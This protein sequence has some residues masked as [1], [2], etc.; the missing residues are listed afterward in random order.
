MPEWIFRA[1]S[2]AFLKR[3]AAALLV[4]PAAY[5][6]WQLGRELIEPG[7][8]LGA[9]PGEAVVLFLGEWSLRVLLATLAVAS[10]ARLL[11]FSPLIRVRRTVGL[12]AFAYV[13]AHFLAYLGFLAVFD[14]TL[15]V[16]DLSERRYITVGFLALLLL[17]PLALTSTRGWQRRLGRRW[18]R[19]HRLIYLIVPLGLVHLFWLTKDGYGEPVLL[20]SIYVLLMLERLRLKLTRAPQPA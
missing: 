14:W 9:D 13:V 11:R 12:F 6:A 1:I 18:K 19:L 17:V 8:A 7:S 4:A 3:A 5:L 10:L 16:E 15:I 20:A 2:E